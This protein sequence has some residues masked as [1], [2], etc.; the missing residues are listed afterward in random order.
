MF[1]FYCGKVRHL[2]RNCVHRKNDA[3]ARRVSE[4]KYREWLK[5]EPNRLGRNGMKEKDKETQVQ[6]AE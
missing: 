3:R 6:I 4:G 1:C 2:K 5:V